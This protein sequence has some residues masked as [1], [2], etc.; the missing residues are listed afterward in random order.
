M[1]STDLGAMLGQNLT[2]L[3]YQSPQLVSLPP[4]F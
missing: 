1:A 2:E 4:K 3:Y